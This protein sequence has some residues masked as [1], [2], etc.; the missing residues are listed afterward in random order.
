MGRT[1]LQVAK[2]FPDRHALPIYL[3]YWPTGHTYLDQRMD[4]KNVRK[5]MRIILARDATNNCC[6]H[7]A[8]G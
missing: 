1:I 5:K 2:L 8:S 6:L 4:D 7:A 3:Q